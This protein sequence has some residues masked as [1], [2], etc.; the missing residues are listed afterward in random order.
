MSHS[1]SYMQ[2][3]NVKTL[4]R[5]HEQFKADPNSVD[6][7]WRY[8]FE[9]VEFGGFESSKA[10]DVRSFDLIDMYRRYGHLK[11]D[12]NPIALM[13][14]ASPAELNLA[15]ASLNASDLQ[16]SFPT[17]GILP[18]KEAPLEKIIQR[19]E[20]I[21][22][23]TI[24]FE[25]MTCPYELQHFIRKRVEVMRATLSIDQKQTILKHL[26]RAELFEL[27]LHKRYVGQKRFSLEGAETLI[28]IMN[29]IVDSGSEAGVREI[30][31][32]MAH[33]GR[34]NVLTNVL[35]KSYRM[36]FSEFEDFYDPKW[37]GGDG[38][39]KYHKGFSST[40][41]ARGAHLVRL[42]VTA[43]P[44]HL[45]S[46]CP[47]V[48]GR[49]FAKQIQKE[50]EQKIETLAVLVHGDASLPGQGIVYETLQ[51]SGLKG[52]GTGGTIH[53]C[54]ENQIGFTTTSSEYRSMRYSTDLANSFGYPVFHVNAD[55]PE[56]SVFA[57]N[58]ALEIRQKFHVDV[59][60]NMVCYRKYGHN[61][62]DEPLFT[63]PLQYQLI[64][65]KKSVRELYRDH[66]IEK[67]ALVTEMALQ[68]EKEFQKELTL[69][70]DEMSQKKERSIESA[71]E[72]RWKPF[73]KADK[74]TLFD[75]V[76]TAVC[77][78][79]LKKIAKKFSTIPEGFAIH[80]KLQKL[81]EERLKRIDGKIDWALAE[82]LAFASLLLEGVAV[83][84]SGQDSQRGT[85]TQRHAVWVDQERGASYY[86]LSNLSKGQA[87]F[88]VYNSPLSEFAVLG[89]EF[90]YSLAAPYSLVLWEAQFGDFANGA[91]V[92]ID[93]Y[94][95]VSEQKWRRFSGLVLLLPHGYEGQGAEHSSAR[96]ERY[97]QLCGNGNMQVVYPTT[98]AQYFHL[99]RRQIIREI[100][101]P[102]IVM[103]PKGLLRHPECVS[104]L[105]DFESG[106][107]EEI[108]DG[109]V[110]SEVRLILCS[111]RIYYDLLAKN[112]K[113]TALV[114]IEQLYP[115]AKDQLKA[116]LKKYNQAKEIIW[117]QEEPQNMGAW[118]YIYP[119]LKKMGIV[120]VRYVGRKR[121]AATATGS[122]V[123]HDKEQKQLI[124]QAYEE[125]H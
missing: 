116:L 99:L 53:I 2:L 35:G 94:L 42:S 8:F 71:F 59:F 47:V 25:Y 60:I 46:V 125:E 9:G 4:E 124:E 111:G 36:V 41:S 79:T 77:G 32:G 14:I 88:D 6:A 62:G 103:T 80:T 21:Y 78:K 34:L 28:P 11:A 45:E 63:Q 51:L 100:R 67:G 70:V 61:E 18:Q 90:G 1:F 96:I 16:K 81:V 95:S 44:S 93:Q 65:K 3:A 108:L 97:L 52:Y 7:S 49:V 72:D 27:F 66:L 121:A 31:I 106:T 120:H 109:G 64:Q 33:R 68:L 122:H 37:M 75:R 22:C 26:N 123:M 20:Q 15:R 40:V 114:R 117:V 24:G 19:L 118:N 98:P 10:L 29:E 83:R 17:F 86:P 89:F 105:A 50:D 38:D 55:D 13:P 101:I 57:A 48:E 76:Q 23:G 69:E 58:L 112:R 54:I 84:L 43:N 73:R 110:G 92:I 107:F 87:R 104:S 30:I 74:A 113:D 56:A 5:L 91:Q 39:V 102:L 119:I 85:F 115:L 12:I 82:H